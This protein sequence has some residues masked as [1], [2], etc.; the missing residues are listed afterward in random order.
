MSRGPVPT[1][2]AWPPDLARPSNALPITFQPCCAISSWLDGPRCPHPAECGASHRLG[3]ACGELLPR[4]G[5]RPFLGAHK[6]T[7]LGSSPRALTTHT[8]KL[9]PQ[10]KRP[11][12]P[13]FSPTGPPEDWQ[14]LW[15][16]VSNTKITPYSLK[17]GMGTGRGN[18]GKNKQ[19]ICDLNY[20]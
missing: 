16:S 20:P 19:H 8:H 3:E 15:S 17:Q 18:S 14:N 7:R 1:V 2:K 5:A 13:S 12:T 11:V 6:H 10:G 9:K 4:P